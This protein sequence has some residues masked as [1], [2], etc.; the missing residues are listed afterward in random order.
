[1]MR[2]GCSMLAVAAA[3]AGLAAQAAG[4][5]W[6]AR[7][8]LT[9]AQYQSE[10]NK[11]T[12]QGYRPTVIS[13]HASGGQ[14]LYAAIF[15][16]T[17]NSPAW[18]ARHGLTPQQYQTEVNTQTAQGYR[19]VRISGYAVSTDVRYAVIFEKTPNAPAWTARHGM[20][21]AE[22]QSE[23]N[24]YTG[25]G[26]RLA[27]LSGYGVGPQAQFAAIWEKSAN[28]PAWVACHGLSPAEYQSAFNTFSGQG[29]RLIEVSG[30]TDG[31]QPRYAAIFAPESS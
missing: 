10:F 25:Q 14:A 20:S 8:G 15:A 28:M 1:M 12:A 24:K 4:Q 5:P 29:Y 21:A 19:P 2:S 26:Y 30:Y 17:A 22:Y 6:V 7:H 23:F 13:G 9:A 11:Y 16:K 18:V 3:F 31:G 27:H